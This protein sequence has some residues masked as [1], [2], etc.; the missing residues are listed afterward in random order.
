[1][2]NV[3]VNAGPYIIE[4]I[5]LYAGSHLWD[6]WFTEA[7]GEQHRYTIWN[8]FGGD[9]EDAELNNTLNYRACTEGVNYVAVVRK[10]LG[11]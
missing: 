8:Q 9:V 1:M 7:H 4:F 2:D 6:V 10:A 11:G 3:V 5:R